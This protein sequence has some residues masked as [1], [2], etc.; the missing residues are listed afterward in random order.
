LLNNDGDKIQL[1]DATENALYFTSYTSFTS[2]E[3][4]T[5]GQESSTDKISNCGE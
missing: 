5:S 3:P 2:N 1:Q 4:R